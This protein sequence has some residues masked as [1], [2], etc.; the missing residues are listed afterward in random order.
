MNLVG[1]VIKPCEEK[2]QCVAC[3]YKNTVTAGMNPML[4]NFNGEIVRS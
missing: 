2:T 3:I 4:W 1:H